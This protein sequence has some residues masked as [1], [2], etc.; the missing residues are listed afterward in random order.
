MQINPT[1]G[2]LIGVGILGIIAL[3]S[4]QSTTSNDIPLNQS[5]QNRANQLGFVQV[6]GQYFPIEQA[7]GLLNRS[8]STMELQRTINTNTALQNT[9]LNVQP[10]SRPNPIL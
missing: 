9:F 8:Q 2:I 6:N 10:Q 5:A 1:T 4:N 7:N 3:A